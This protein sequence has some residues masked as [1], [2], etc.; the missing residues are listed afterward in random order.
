MTSLG[1]V[2]AIY[3]HTSS[4]FPAILLLVA[5][6]LHV[7]VS[8]SQF[9]QVLYRN[10]RHNRPLCEASVQT[11]TY[12]IRGSEGIQ[13]SDAVHVH[14]RLSVAWKPRAGH[15]IYLCIP[16][17]SYTSFAELHPFYVAWWYRKPNGT[18]WDDYA[19][20]IVRK[21]SGFTRHLFKR[22]ELKSK[23][24][25]LEG[26]YGKELDLDGYGTVL[27]FATGI[28]IAGQLAYVAQLLQG[29]NN[30]EVRTRRIALFWQLD[31]ES[32][33]CRRLCSPI[34]LI[35]MLVHSAWVADRM[36]ELMK[37]DINKVC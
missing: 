11:I 35:F 19:V 21:E 26:P 8:A 28:G 23:R 7:L 3:L 13:L 27:L 37:E 2:A 24:A 4:Q 32:K 29:Y 12:G 16:G 22:R 36:Q 20:F 14:V 5:I 9:A 10:F 17:V 18:D 34:S 33:C 25:I 31:A 30:H 6:C 1:A 15:Y